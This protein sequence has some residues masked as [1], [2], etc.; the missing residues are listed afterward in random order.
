MG[1]EGRDKKVA[2]KKTEFKPKSAKNDMTIRYD[3]NGGK[4]A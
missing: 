3:Q 1:E 2:S 4:M